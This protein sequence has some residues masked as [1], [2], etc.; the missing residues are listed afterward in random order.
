QLLSVEPHGF[1]FAFGYS[2]YC[3]AWSGHFTAL[4]NAHAGHTKNHGSDLNSEP[5]MVSP[6]RGE[7]GGFYYD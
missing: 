2:S 7:R 4:D 5:W 6:G 3:Q 1:P